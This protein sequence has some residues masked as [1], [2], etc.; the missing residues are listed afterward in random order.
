MSDWLSGDVIANGIK[1]HYLRT[2]GAKPPLV[3]AH[4]LTDNSLCW[5]PLVQRLEQAYDCIM[6]DARGHGQSDAPDAGYTGADH[7]ADYV[8][9]IA[10]LHL[11]KPAMI[12]HS[13]GAATSAYLA[14]HY[15]D[16]VSAIVLEDPP[17]RSQAEK[18]TPEQA[19]AFAEA[20]RARVMA[21]HGLTR[22][23]L[24]EEG[25]KDRPAWSAAEFEGWATAKQQVSPNAL[26]YAS[27]LSKPWWEF[28]AKINCPALLVTAD[29][30]LGAVVSP[31]TARSAVAL[32][33][34]IRMAHIAGAG[35]NIR[36]EQF[37]PYVRTVR[38]FLAEVAR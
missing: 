18:A 24:I 36:R 20:W 3:L 33:P 2:G 25:R 22:A 14:A 38:E 8:G 13:M 6:V 17:W 29:V 26:N 32:N 16:L 27:E 31:A 34:N 30:A 21:Q 12:G 4:G 15:P 11:S 5:T 10:A 1:I 23:E 19:T 7:A 28:V 35:H 9:V 37:E